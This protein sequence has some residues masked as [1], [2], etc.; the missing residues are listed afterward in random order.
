MYKRQAL[1]QP[2]WIQR[3]SNDIALPSAL[4]LSRIIYTVVIYF[5]SWKFLKLVASGLSSGLRMTVSGY[6]AW[7]LAGLFSD[8]RVDG[9]SLLVY[10][11]DYF[12]FYFRF[13]I[14]QKQLY[15]NKGQI[16]KQPKPMNKIKRKG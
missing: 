5:L 1:A 16:Y 11:K 6:L 7:T 10:L 12:I 15:I 3:I 9:K 2:I 4:K 8:L 13:G 14:R